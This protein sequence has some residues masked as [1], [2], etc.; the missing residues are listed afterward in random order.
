MELYFSISAGTSQQ[1]GKVERK[2]HHILDTIRAL[3]IS[4]SCPEIF[5]GEASFIVVY[6]INLMPSSVIGN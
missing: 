6:N 5:W 3:L 1:N 2:C 4:A